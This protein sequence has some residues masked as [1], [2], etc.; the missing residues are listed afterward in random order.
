MHPFTKRFWLL[1]TLSFITS[2]QSQI[3]DPTPFPSPNPIDVPTNKPTQSPVYRITEFPTAF[4]TAFPTV[5]PTTLYPTDYPTTNPS[6]SSESPTISP[7]VAPSISPTISPTIAPHASIIP[8][9]SPTFTN[10][11]IYTRQHG[12]D[13]GYCSSQNTRYDVQNI[14]KTQN[15]IGMSAY[16][17]CCIHNTFNPTN[18]PTSLP[19]LS[20]KN[21]PT[22]NPSQL[23]TINPST[24]PSIYPTVGPTIVT[25][26]PTLSPTINSINS[27]NQTIF[28]PT[29]Y[30]TVMNATGF[31]DANNFN[32]LYVFNEP[33]TNFDRPMWIV[34]QFPDNK[35]LLFT[36]NNW[37][38]NGYGNER[39]SY[40]SNNYFPDMNRTWKHSI[41]SGNFKVSIHCIESYSPTNAPTISPTLVTHSPTLPTQYLH[42]PT[43]FP[44]LSPTQSPTQ[45]GPTKSPTFAPTQS[46]TFS[47]TTTPVYEPTCATID[48]SWNCFLGLG[49]YPNPS[50]CAL[51]G[52]DAN[53]VYDLG[54]G[55]WDFKYSLN[56]DD[57]NIIIRGQVMDKTYLNY[58]GIES[59]WIQCR[60]P[61]C[62][63]SL[64]DLTL[65]SNRTNIND[66]QFK[67]YNGGTLF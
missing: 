40:E 23:P 50:G 18:N 12:C 63:L 44:T 1:F 26:Q 48:Y 66:E 52:Y 56:F 32:G 9:T 51:V 53:G 47:P 36:G 2:I 39:L 3:V 42:L 5:Y 6:K 4:P 62:W 25:F 30:I 46:P 22:V 29:I 33:V 65:I 31:F 16:N 41:V 35:N 38:I 14:C 45:S 10:K 34:P 28:C 8:T 21:N 43:N 37:L 61:K 27:L 19:S 20:P 13:F 7:T 11:Y 24:N 64:Q 58:I 55:T 17:Y 54:N 60:W 49:G 57:N 59:I 67:M 15:N